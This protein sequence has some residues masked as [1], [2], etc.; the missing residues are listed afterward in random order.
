MQV[1]EAQVGLEDNIEP[2]LKGHIKKVNE[3]I[4]NSFDKDGNPDSSKY[5]LKNVKKF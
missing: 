3:Y 5:K 1:A 4:G 2:K